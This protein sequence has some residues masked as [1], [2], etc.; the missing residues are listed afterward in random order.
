MKNAQV[1]R[2]NQDSRNREVLW[3]QRM[4]R[5]RRRD[6]WQRRTRA[7]YQLPMPLLPPLLLLLFLVR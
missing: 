1:W 5:V 2:R 6:E 7:G 3:C 4:L